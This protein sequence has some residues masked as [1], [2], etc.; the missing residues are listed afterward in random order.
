MR[1]NRRPGLSTWHL[2]DFQLS[3][4]PSPSPPLN[5][6]LW[7]SPHIYST[8]LLPL[9]NYMKL[10]WHITVMFD[11]NRKSV[12][13]QFLLSFFS[14]KNWDN[15]FIC[16]IIHEFLPFFN[17]YKSFLQIFTMQIHIYLHNTN[18]T[19]VLFWVILFLYLSKNF[20][21]LVIT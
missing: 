20:I 21:T 18:P 1:H 16:L 6:K 12:I 11:G 9:H 19:K 10:L 2:Q 4:P 3:H 13:I 7:F 14:M 8:P 5:Q 17:A 15:N